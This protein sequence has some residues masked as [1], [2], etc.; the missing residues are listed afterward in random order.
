VTV[1]VPPLRTHPLKGVRDAMSSLR[2]ILE[3][4]AND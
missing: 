4:A 1:E 2:L 3:D